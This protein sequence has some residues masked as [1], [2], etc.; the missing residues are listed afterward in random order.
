MTTL[1]RQ[2]IEAMQL[3]GLSANT[4]ASYLQAIRLLARHYGRPPDQLTDEELRQ[5]FLFLRNDRQ[6]SRSTATVTLCAIKFL[7]EYTL[8]RPWPLLDLIRAPRARTLPVVLSREEVRTVLALVHTPRHRACL[9]TIYACGLRLME[10]VRLRVS[11]IDSARMLIHIQGGKGNKDR[12]VPLPPAALTILRNH[13]R[14]HRHPVWLF[15]SSWGIDGAIA[16]APHPMHRDGVQRAFRLAVEASRTQKHATVHTL[17]H[18]WATHLLEAGVNLRVIQV[19][20]GHSSAITTAHY[21]HLT[22]QSE[23]TAL[24]TSQGVFADLV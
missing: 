5:Y 9:T 3:R 23:A 21:T 6:V 7:Y 12:Y 18:S 8:R 24:T 20:L 17:R 10:G 13:W 16:A 14:T 15:P 22:Q 19:W 2:M 1:R 4:Q 11:Q